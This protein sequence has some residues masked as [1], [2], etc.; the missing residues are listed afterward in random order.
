MKIDFEYTTKYGKFADALWFPD[1][2]PMTD[3]EIAAE[4]QR[5]LDSWIAI[6]EAPP[7]PE[8]PLEPEAQ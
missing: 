5:R 4:K 7:E 3:D 2:A 6:I 1:D 8:A